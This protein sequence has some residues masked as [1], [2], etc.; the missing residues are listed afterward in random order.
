MYQSESINE[1]AGALA[2]AQAEIT[3]AKKDENNPFFNKKY[4]DL[5]AVI[6]AAR[7]ALSKNGLC[8]IQAT[9]MMDDGRVYLVTQLSHSSGQWIRSS[10]PLKPVRDDP[11][12]MGSALTYAR[13]YA[14]ASIVG[15]AASG[16]DDD[17]NAASNP[18]AANDHKPKPETAKARN[19]RYRAIKAELEK[20]EDPGVTWGERKEEIEEFKVSLGGD[21]YQQLVDAGAKRKKDLE[22][23]AI[24]SAGMSQGFNQI[25]AQ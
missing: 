12:G 23:M 15:V 18:G 4:A 19:E 3:H 6:D 7:A 16:E 2:K 10:Y 25:G 24:Q 21:Y 11:Q 13:R 5:P 20:S 8:V 22:Q 9:Q 1:L 17:G 14:Y